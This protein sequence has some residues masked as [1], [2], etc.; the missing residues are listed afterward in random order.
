IVE[1][2]GG[3][4]ETLAAVVEVAMRSGGPV[5][6]LDGTGEAAAA[7]RSGVPELTP[8]S[9]GAGEAVLARLRELAAAG[10]TAVVTG[11]TAWPGLRVG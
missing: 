6:V 1:A 9:E 5:A 8:D 3:R 2:A 7:A 4:A 10:G 11:C